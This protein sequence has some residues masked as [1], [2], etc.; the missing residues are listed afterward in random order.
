MSIKAHCS[1]IAAGAALALLGAP[2]TRA[3]ARPVKSVTFLACYHQKVGRFSAEEHPAGCNIWG[4]RGRKFFGVSVR[5]MNWK[6]WGA[7][8]SRASFGVDVR[9]QVPVRVVAYRPIPCD[10]G[11]HWY[12]RVAVFFPADSS[13][14]ELHLPTCERSS[15]TF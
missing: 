5:D 14:F 11:R 12:S 4:Y 10:D 13:G 9:D 1:V 15:P 3:N 2:S 7:N 6:H 8:R